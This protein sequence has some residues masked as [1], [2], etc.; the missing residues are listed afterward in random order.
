VISS[1]VPFPDGAQAEIQFSLGGLGVSNRLWFQNRQPPTTGPQVQNL[2]D[3]LTAYWT[4]NVMPILS[5]ELALLSVLV[6]SW[7]DPNSPLIGLTSTFV[8]GGSPERSHSAN[9]AIRVPFGWPLDRNLRQNS[10]FVPG[11]PLDQVNVNFFS[12]EIRDALFEA[13]AGLIDAAGLFGPFPA[14]RWVA[15]SLQENGV[16]RSEAFVREV[17]GPRFVTN[18]VSPRRFRTR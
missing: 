16:A 9:V 10:N 4:T 2:A 17:Q 8:P 3:G 6:K 12:S 13:Y 7:D 1:L 18:V 11:V 15:A 5:N 14:W